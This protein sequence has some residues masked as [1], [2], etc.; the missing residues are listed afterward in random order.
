MILSALD[1]F[2]L[3]CERVFT[4]LANTCLA[5]LLASNAVN[6]FSRAI[7]NQAISWVFPWSMVLFVWMVFF[8]FYVFTRRGRSVSVDFI[9]NNV[10]GVSRKTIQLFINAVVLCVLA[11]I[12]YTTPDNLGRQV[13]VIEM[14]GLQRYTLSIPFFA[15]CALVCL[16]AIADSARILRE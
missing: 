6:I 5:V 7:L 14:V 16:N 10:S 12:L 9:V 8:G 2:L 15:S 4:V 3:V 13:G 1:R 11:A